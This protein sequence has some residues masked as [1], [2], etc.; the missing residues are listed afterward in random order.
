MRSG[1]FLKCALEVAV[2]CVLLLAVPSQATSYDPVKEGWALPVYVLSPEGGWDTPEGRSVWSGLMAY[3]EKTAGTRAGIGGYEFEFVREFDK[4][5]VAVIS[6][7]EGRRGNDVVKAYGRQGPVVVSGFGEDLGLREG[8]GVLPYAFALDLPRGC[9]G[10]ALGRYV[11]AY[12]K[13]ERFAPL[14]DPLDIYMRPAVNGFIY[15]LPGDIA[16]FWVQ[17]GMSLDAAFREIRA[18]GVDGI[19]SFLNASDTQYLWVKCKSLGLSLLSSLPLWAIS[20]SLEGIL[21]ADQGWAVDND[22]LLRDVTLEVFDAV[23]VRPECPGMAARAFAVASWLGNA[24][25]L[26]DKVSD[27]RAGMEKAASFSLGSQTLLPDPVTH[28]TRGRKVTVLKLINGNF[29][30][31]CEF[32]LNPDSALEVRL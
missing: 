26:V 2:L 16:P 23:R 32:R 9:V 29:V 25:K 30:P 21:A 5:C 13:G 17:A 18:G 28:R 10:S 20:P 22:P 11:K 4:N 15:E 8:K 27:L 14:A 7:L 19:A 31:L 6:F 12:R 3:R 1:R 24:L